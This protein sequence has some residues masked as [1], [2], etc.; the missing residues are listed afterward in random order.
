MKLRG[1]FDRG[2]GRKSTRRSGGGI[3][4]FVR[5]RAVWFF[6]FTN[7]VVAVTISMAY[8]RV[9]ESN[10]VKV[11]SSIQESEQVCGPTTK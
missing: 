10:S 9:Y 8:S 7:M 1:F 11:P 4:T 2:G 6:I 5:K 3:K